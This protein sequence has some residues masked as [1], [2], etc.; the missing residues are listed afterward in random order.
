MSLSN[1]AI[2]ARVQKLKNKGVDV[3]PPLTED[4]KAGSL[5]TRGY[6]D[7]VMIAM[8][9]VTEAYFAQDFESGLEFPPPDE[10]PLP[11]RLV[12]S[13][14]VSNHQANIDLGATLAAHQIEYCIVRI[15]QSVEPAELAVIAHQQIDT[16]LTHGVHL[17]AYFWL[18]RDEPVQ[19]QVSDVIRF[20]NSH[21]GDSLC[22]NLLWP[23]V[24]P[25]ID[26]SNL[27]TLQQIKASTGFVFDAGYYP[28]MY[29]GPWVWDL[30]GNPID[31][32]LAKLPL[33][34]AEYNGIAALE[35]IRHYGGWASCAGHQYVGNPLDHSVFN[36]TVLGI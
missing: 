20:L 28:G 19:Q 2:N 25:Y 3:G 1:A 26:N 10:P 36:S 33:W 4:T 15:P 12:N 31:E 22:A 7:G 23:D 30:L 27:P 5:V 16:V 9:G 13:L 6:Y 32:D 8:P 18:Y 14:D 21:G 34:T 24:E 29:T 17:G 11:M 35:P